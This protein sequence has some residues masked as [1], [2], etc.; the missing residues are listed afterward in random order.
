MA[1]F[2]IRGSNKHFHPSF[3]ALISL[4]LGVQITMRPT[5]YSRKVPGSANPAASSFFGYSESAEK[6]RSKG[7]PFSIWVRKLP[8]D[9]YVRSNFD[10]LA[11]SNWAAN[12]AMANFKSA[13]AATFKACARAYEPTKNAGSRTRIRFDGILIV[14]R[15]RLTPQSSYNLPLKSVNSAVAFRF[16]AC[17]QCGPA[18]FSRRTKRRMLR[19]PGPARIAHLRIA[20]S[21]TP[22]QPE[23]SPTCA[24]RGHRNR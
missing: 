18:F 9:P 22:R 10:A 11:F 6:N 15:K 3:A 14:L 21:P 7:A 4:S 1:I 23:Y 12:S 8:L 17:G 24:P 16:L 5:A 2:F 19:A 13:A 20:A